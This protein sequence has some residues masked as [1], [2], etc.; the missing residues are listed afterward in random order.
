MPRRQPQPGLEH[1]LN[2]LPEVGGANPLFDVVVGARRSLLETTQERAVATE[3]HKRNL[4]QPGIGP[5]HREEIPA[6]FFGH[7][8]VGDDDVGAHRHRCVVAARAVVGGVDRIPGML[9]G[10]PIQGDQGLIIVDEQDRRQ[11][12]RSLVAQRQR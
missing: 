12:T 2:A 9:K 3:Q 7:G 11:R 10:T 5:H 1:S 8:D 4:A 6:I